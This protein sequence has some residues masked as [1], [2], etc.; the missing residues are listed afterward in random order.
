MNRTAGKLSLLLLLT[1]FVLWIVLLVLLPHVQMLRISFQVRES[2]DSLDWGVTQYSNFFA[3]SYYWRTFIRTGVMSLL[4][5]ALTLVIGFPI[6]WYIAK[7]ARGRARGLLFLACLIPFW[8]SELVRTYGWMILLRESGLFSSWLQALGWVDGPVEFLYNDV[9]VIVGLVY[10][11]LLFMVVPLVTTLDGLDDN[12]VEAGYDLGGNHWHVLRDIVVP[13]AMPGIVSGCIVVFMLTLGSYLTP[14][15][16][17]GKDSAWFTQQI[18]TQFITRFNW[19]QGAAL[20]VLLLVLSSLLVWL[21]L[22]LTGQNLRKV[23]G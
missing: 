16:M 23:L 13:W 7:L 19:E 6:A 11:A 3:E 17:G 15:L 18:F 10:N 5:T 2:W 21:G 8:A 1:P 22:R 9:A 20:G 12:L 4:T 14:T